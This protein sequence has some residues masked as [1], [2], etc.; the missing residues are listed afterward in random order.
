MEDS[1]IDCP[2]CQQKIYVSDWPFCP[3]GKVSHNVITDDIPGGILIR[4]GLC[5]ENTGEPVRYYSKTE[6]AKEAKRRGV[7]NWVEHV[8]E[9]GSDKSRH[10]TRWV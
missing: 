6:I 7:V 8:P 9:R 1:S 3:H 5:D 4:H 10:T 2:K